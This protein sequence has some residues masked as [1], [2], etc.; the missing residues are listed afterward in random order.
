MNPFLY[1]TLPPVSNSKEISR[2]NQV[3]HMCI[4]LP[5]PYIGD[6]AVPLKLTVVLKSAASPGAGAPRQL[7]TQ[8]WWAYVSSRYAKPNHQ[9]CL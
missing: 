8:I 4:M 5:F 6:S 7:T 9:Y 3:I 1:C 2:K